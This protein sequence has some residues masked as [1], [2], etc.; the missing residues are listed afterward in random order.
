[1]NLPETLETLRRR[2]PPTLLTV[3][4]SLLVLVAGALVLLPYG[5][6]WYLGEWLRDRGV[7]NV[8]IGDVDINPFTGTF[9]IQSLEY[10]DDG[11]RRRAGHV[12]LNVSWIDLLNQRIRLSTVELRDASLEIRRTESSGWLLGTIVIGAQQA[13]EGAE[14]T[15]AESGWGFGIDQLLVED[16]AIAYRD[17]LIVREFVI[18][19]ASLNDL[20]T[21][22]PEHSATLAVALSSGDARLAASGNVRPFADT[23]DLDLRV[24][25]ENLDAAGLG[26]LLQRVGIESVRG[27]LHADFRLKVIAPPADADTSL[28][29][30]GG[31]KLDDWEVIRRTDRLALSGLDWDGR[32]DVSLGA[33]G[34]QG[35]AVVL[36]GALDVDDLVFT[37]ATSLI[38]ATL[39]SVQWQGRAG[40]ADRD[41]W[42]VHAGGEVVARQL[43]VG[44]AGQK[45]TLLNVSALHA[46]LV[47]AKPGDMVS[48][49]AVEVVDLRLFE[50][51]AVDANEPARVVSVA[52]IGID[53]MSIATDMLVL[54]PV[55]VSDAQLWLVRTPD[56]VLEIDV[57]SGG[58]T[59]SEAGGA[60]DNDQASKDPG[61][62]FVLAGLKVAGK[63][64]LVYVDRSVR[65]VA[66]LELA[67][68]EIELGKVDAASP[69]NDT[70]ISFTASQGRYG[71][72]ALTGQ[73]RP[74]AQ[75]TYVNAEGT[76]TDL[77]MIGLDGFAR[78]AIGYAIK[79]GTLSA[80]IDVDLQDQRLDSMA[81]LTIRKLEIDPLKPEDQDEFSTE[82][83]VPLG[84]ALG[85]LEDDQKTIRLS[86]PLKGELSDLSVGVGDA[87]R[88]VMQKGLVAGMQAAATAYFAPLWPALA[89]TKL[90]AAASKLSFTAVTFAPG[91]SALG[92]EQLAYLE[93]MAVLLAKRPKVSLTMCGRAVAA[94]RT[95]IYPDVGGELDDA[96]LAALAELSQLRHEAAKDR[97]VEAGIDSARLVTC[98]PEASPE[99]ELMPRV[100]FSA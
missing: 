11:K 30:T 83:G 35:I 72:L 95:V 57:P 41:R 37:D 54:G 80:D 61:V 81:D 53:Q 26:A 40:A 24:K 50:R 34:G 8:R 1:M 20:A 33:D 79:S 85:L 19:A 36:D 74:L 46:A 52:R 9:A 47:D 67:A 4:I 99:D 14:R 58:D 90:F 39:G 13:V 82:L 44:Y 73:L 49:G 2:V 23:S 21:W 98:K 65:P 63:S 84:T 88:L 64:R 29:I 3:L 38:D 56:G 45:R 51:V 42:R 6:Q 62:G 76:I 17:P 97:L 75:Q 7:V 96:Q 28:S 94:D 15:E 86:V 43:S 59:G 100:D 31:L 89:A 69:D 16:V 78:R 77:N 25:G 66:R 48:F 70:P 93:N 91:D 10:E 71:K 5:V 92:T 32:V 18:D 68:L 22:N 55:L 27:L 87:V 60:T 12:L